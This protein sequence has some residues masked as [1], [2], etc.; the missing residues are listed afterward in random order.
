MRF[1]VLAY[2]FDRALKRAVFEIDESRAV[3]GQVTALHPDVLKVCFIL[4][5]RDLCR[6]SPHDGRA[7]VPSEVGW[8]M[9]SNS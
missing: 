7:R 8:T 9:E 2:Y 5:L 4:L 3:D 1:D 6:R